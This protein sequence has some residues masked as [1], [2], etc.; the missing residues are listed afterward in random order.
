M[1]SWRLWDFEVNFEKH[2]HCDVAHSEVGIVVGS[3]TTPSTTP[4]ERGHDGRSGLRTCRGGNKETLRGYG[5]RTR[6]ELRGRNDRDPKGSQVLAGK[7]LSAVAVRAPGESGHLWRFGRAED[8]GWSPGKVVGNQSGAPCI[9]CSPLLGVL[10]LPT[11]ASVTPCPVPHV[12]QK[13]TESLACD[14][15]RQVQGFLEMSSVQEK[16][17]HG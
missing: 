14:T 8:P 7:L 6:R 12:C 11:W 15:S 3:G 5:E 2:T 17:P 9:C 13:L 16:S 1:T 4:G 10:C